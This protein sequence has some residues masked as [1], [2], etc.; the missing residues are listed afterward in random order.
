MLRMNV[1]NTGIR[2]N[3]FHK[4]YLIICIPMYVYAIR[5]LVQLLRKVDCSDRAA[6]VAYL[7]RA[8]SQPYWRITD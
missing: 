3:I 2:G 8:D 7:W 6:K 5:N 1:L 4:W